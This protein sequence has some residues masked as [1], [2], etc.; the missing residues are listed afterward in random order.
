M[1]LGTSYNR[2]GSGL[3][4][5]GQQLI[6]QLVRSS[7]SSRTPSSAQH[8]DTLTTEPA[9]RYQQ[10]QQQI[11]PTN[12]LPLDVIPGDVCLNILSFLPA[13]ELCAVRGTCW[14]LL[15][16]AD[17]HSDVLWEHLCRWDFPSVSPAHEELF[18]PH[19][20]RLVLNS[21]V[22]RSN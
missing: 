2:L 18:S 12:P 20:V 22:G 5:I 10:Q 6:S 14:G 11:S 4:T 7:S 13:V 21:W 15:Q 9:Y 16:T 19:Q 17:E 8:N 1:D 3:R